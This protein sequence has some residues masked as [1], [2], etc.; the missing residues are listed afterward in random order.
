VFNKA[1]QKLFKIF[2]LGTEKFL[3]ISVQSTVQCDKGFDRKYYRFA[4]VDLRVPSLGFGTM[5]QGLLFTDL[6][7]LI[8]GYSLGVEKH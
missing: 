3:S 7:Q 4:P 1:K 8:W 2:T 5:K 6:Y